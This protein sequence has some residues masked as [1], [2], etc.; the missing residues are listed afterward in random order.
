MSTFTEHK[1]IAD[2]SASDRRRHKQKIEKAIKDG[3]H[4][5][6]ADESIIG[7]DGKKKIKIPVR[8]IKEYRFVYGDNENNKKVGSAPGADIKRGQKIGDNKQKAKGEP[9]KPG[10]DPGEEYYDVEITLEELAHYLFDDLQ[11]PDL[12]K[13]SL[14]KVMSEKIKRK[15]YRKEGI[16]P[17][18]DKKKSAIQRIKRK[19]A[20]ERISTI[21]EDENFPF[22]ENDLIYRH[23]KPAKKECSNAV[24]FFVMDISGSM[25]KQK[26]F[27]ARSFYFLLYH[28]IRSKYEHTEIVFVSHDTNAYEVNE[29]QFFNRGNSGGTLVS[30]GLEM[31]RDIISKRFHPNS[32]NIYC[33]Q[34]SDGDNWPEDTSKTL[35]A[36]EAIRD[37]SQLFG[38]CEII[39]GADNDN[40]GWFDDSRLSKVYEPIASKK[41]KIVSITSKSD[42]WPSFKRLFGGRGK[43]R[44]IVSR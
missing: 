21:N 22:H 27:I 7:Q 33:F 16:K 24:I 34:C 8:G 44:I 15:G 28:F 30:S 20:S 35:A 10:N 32:W 40:G 36:A 5:I 3:I 2:R 31:V 25:T 29:E 17:R 42:I 18:L 38:Y 11:L 39:P 9:N 12:E 43:K 19:K 1:T 41:M 13:K 14:K 26:K 4:D 23:F 37:V 6:V